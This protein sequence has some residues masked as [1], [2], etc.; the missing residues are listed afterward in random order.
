MIFLKRAM[1]KSSRTAPLVKGNRYFDLRQHPQYISL[2][3]YETFKKTRLAYYLNCDPISNSYLTIKIYNQKLL[4]YGKK[5]VISKRYY[6]IECLQKLQPDIIIITATKDRL[7]YLKKSFQNLVTSYGNFTC[8]WLIVDN[9]SRDNTQQWVENLRD[10]RVFY[11]P[12]VEKTGYA[13]SVRNFGL[14]IVHAALG[15]YPNKSR[16]VCIIDSDD[17]LADS[18]S[19]Y[20]LIKTAKNYPRS[21]MWHG[22]AN[23]IYYTPEGD[24]SYNTI[25]RRIDNA[26]FPSVPNLTE[27]LAAGP[28]ILASIIPIEF[29]SYLRY[30][31]DFSFEDDTLCQKI[32]FTAM[33]LSSNWVAIE[34]PIIVKVFHDDSM[35]GKNNKWGSNK[36]GKIGAWNVTG[37]RALLVERLYQLRDFY[38]ENGL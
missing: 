18:Y 14:D 11:V 36:T 10:A 4:Y 3:K 32:L 9:L 2:L 20:E 38:L 23:C 5:S 6:A 8:A 12:Y 26:I 25:P 17:T 27:E 7:Q 29:L 31:D 34:Y 35:G 1:A 33:R 21:S 30:P 16:Y 19:L 24:V 28:N 37:V 13:A 22:F 15:F